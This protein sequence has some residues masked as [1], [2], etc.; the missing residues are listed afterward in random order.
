M[1]CLEVV[2]L[3]YSR[4]VAIVVDFPDPVG[5]VM[6]MIHL[7]ANVA[8]SIESG[9]EISAGLGIIDGI[10]RIAMVIHRIVRDIFTRN[11]AIP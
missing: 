5:P 11:L 6:R 8:L 2:V 7:S 1:I 10:I 9:R 4:S 3:I